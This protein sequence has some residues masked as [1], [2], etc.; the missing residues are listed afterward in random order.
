MY[1]THQ[2]Y[3]IASISIATPKL[4]NASPESLAS[5]LKQL[6]LEVLIIYKGTVFSKVVQK[7]FLNNFAKDITFVDN[8]YTTFLKV[9]LNFQVM[10]Y[11]TWVLQSLLKR[12]HTFGR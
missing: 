1:T 5:L 8:R 12:F 7:S 3:G 9:M 2:K 10:H 4:N 6:C 11:S